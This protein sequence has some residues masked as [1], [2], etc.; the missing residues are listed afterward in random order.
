MSITIIY[1]KLKLFGAFKNLDQDEAEKLA[2]QFTLLKS[3]RGS[4]YNNMIIE[5]AGTRYHSL[6]EAY[7]HHLLLTHP[8]VQDIKTQVRYKLA[9]MEGKKTL[10]YVADFVVTNQDGVEFIID[11]KGRLTNE[12]K[13]KLGYF[14]YVY[15]KPVMLVETSGPN[16]FRLD[17]L[18]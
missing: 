15:E 13:I 14:R 18:G 5:Y 10:S 11:V 7:Y 3:G 1:S 17:F 4:K 6:S 16:K 12:N 8:N 2:K 9:N